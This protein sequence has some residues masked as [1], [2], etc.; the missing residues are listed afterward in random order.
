M[1]TMTTNTRE[2][3][4]D[5]LVL[6]AYQY[7][8]LINE[9]QTAAGSQWD[10][11]SAY[12]RTQLEIIVDQLGAEG[13]FERTMEWYDVVYDASATYA[14][15]PSDTVDIRGDAALYQDDVNGTLLPLRQMTRDEYSA[16]TIPLTG[17]NPGRFYVARGVP[18]KLHLWPVPET[19]RTVR[20]QRQRLSYDNSSGTATVDLERYWTDY[21]LNE[22]AARLAL[23]AGLS[24]ER[25]AVYTAKAVAAKT[26]ARGKS[27]DQLPNRMVVDHMGP[28]GR[29]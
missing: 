5:K 18:M 24:V 26:A 28:W 8:G 7:A 29:R 13:I 23:G 4:I 20:V 3:N 15:L 11:R 6:T 25:A 10:A 14:T 21:L 27:T 1:T 17:G 22:L 9:M 12:G 19:A 16:L 2:L